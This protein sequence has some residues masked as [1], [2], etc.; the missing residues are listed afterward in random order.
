MEKTSGDLFGLD[1]SILLSSAEIE[2]YVGYQDYQ[3]ISDIIP[4]CS[5]HS[6][7][8]IA[9]EFDKKEVRAEILH[10][11]LAGIC[12]HS[13][14]APR[15]KNEKPAEEKNGG[16]EQTPMQANTPPQEEAPEKAAPPA[17]APPMPHT[18]DPGPQVQPV[19]TEKLP[20]WKTDILA[21]YSGNG[22][23]SELVHMILDKEPASKIAALLQERIRAKEVHE[24]ADMEWLFGCEAGTGAEQGP[25]MELLPPDPQEIQRKKKAGHAPFP[26]IRKKTDPSR[27]GHFLRLKKCRK[28]HPGGNDVPPTIREYTHK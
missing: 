15:K 7:A 21:H 9:S 8:Q 28:D 2:N 16:A 4:P 25:G 24:H 22:H 19:E 3:E 10:K 26:L 17:T 27:H 6:L 20:E 23:F 14:A 18:Q 11:I 5:R 13:P 12:N 1:P